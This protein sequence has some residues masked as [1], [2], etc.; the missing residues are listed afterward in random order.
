MKDIQFSNPDTSQPSTLPRRNSVWRRFLHLW[1][2]AAIYMPLLLMGAFA[3]GTFWL[4][5]N[6]PV[7]SAPQTVREVRHEVD[8]FMRDF[9]VKTFDDGG[10]LKS[11]IYGQE[12]RHFSDTDIL[13]IDQ[14]RIRSV[15]AQGLL[16]TATANR[17]YANG[18]GSEVQ[19]SGN[20]LVVREASKA[21]NGEE[22]PRLEFRGEFLHAFLNEERVK[23]H[24][25]VILIRGLDRF[26]GN[27]LAYDNLDQVALLT[28]R[29][30]GV[31]MPKSTGRST[32]Q[33][34]TNGRSNQPGS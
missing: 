7:F 31:L 9:I 1:D 14:A 10:K 34:L 3:S 12:A 6:T 24:K 26:T 16:T 8:Y 5:R 22:T 30:R 28:G 21:A 27:T 4:V 13:E 33:P 23:S 11:E 20:A 18:D 32:G 29:V 2:R 15:N 17:A 19:L 25:P